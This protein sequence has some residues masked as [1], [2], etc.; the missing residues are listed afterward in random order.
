MEIKE[1]SVNVP[2]HMNIPSSITLSN[3]IPSVEGHN[4]NTKQHLNE[5]P[6][7]QATNSHMTNVNEP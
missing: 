5:E 7:H 3:V 6:S 1:I 4:D 2:L